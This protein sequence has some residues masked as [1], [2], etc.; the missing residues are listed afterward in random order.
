MKTVNCKTVKMKNNKQENKQ[1]EI[2]YNLLPI[3]VMKDG[4]SKTGKVYP[5]RIY[6]TKEDLIMLADVYKDDLIANESSEYDDFNLAQ[7]LCM[8]ANQYPVAIEII[9]EFKNKYDQLLKYDIDFQN[10]IDNFIKNIN[11]NEI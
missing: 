6:S 10:K 7:Y 4:F 3:F 11:T 2:P 1:I 5:H 8:T 9:K